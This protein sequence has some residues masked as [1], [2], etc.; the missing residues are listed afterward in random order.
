MK[1]TFYLVKFS[2]MNQKNPQKFEIQNIIFLISF[3]ILF[4]LIVCLY[5]IVKKITISI[6]KIIYHNFLII[7]IYKKNM[8]AVWT[9]AGEKKILLIC[10]KKLNLFRNLFK[11]HQLNLSKIFFEH[12]RLKRDLEPLRKLNEKKKVNIEFLRF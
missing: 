5:L 6:I 9:T 1:K 3:P 11:I 7:Q 8:I 10:K 12:F 2:M 4:L